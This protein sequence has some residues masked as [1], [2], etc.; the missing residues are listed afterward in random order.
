[1]SGGHLKCMWP[2]D[3]TSIALTF[4]QIALFDLSISLGLKP[5]GIV[6][7]SVGEMAVL[8]A[9]GGAIPCSMQLSNLRLLVNVTGDGA[10]GYTNKPC[11]VRYIELKSHL[12]IT[13][14]SPSLLLPRL[15]ACF[16][17]ARGSSG[18][19][20]TAVNEPMDIWPQVKEAE[21]KPPPSFPT[22]DIDALDGGSSWLTSDAA[23]SRH[24]TMS[25]WTFSTHHMHQRCQGPMHANPTASQLSLT[26]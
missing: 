5:S 26:L 25:N 21:E 6:G 24:E 12:S 10:D 9:S 13:L 18:T 2:F 8:Y 14:P 20:C 22:K 23:S 4:F 11:P 19:A 1:M 17:T 3:I 7:H 15:E 16:R